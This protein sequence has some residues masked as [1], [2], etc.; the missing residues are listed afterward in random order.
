[1]Y[2]TF[3]NFRTNVAPCLSY[4]D[5]CC[6]DTKITLTQ[7]YKP[8]IPATTISDDVLKSYSKIPIIDHKYSTKKPSNGQ[9]DEYTKKQSDHHKEEHTKDSYVAHNEEDTEKTSNV[10]KVNHSKDS[11]ITNNVEVFTEK[12][13]AD[14]FIST[15][16]TI[17]PLMIIKNT[18]NV[19]FGINMEL[20]L[21]L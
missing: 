4:L 5:V 16:N 2:P 19:V 10:Y 13:I 20:V 11:Y 1:V 3:L 21:E 18:I 6:S 17:N 9:N 15:T 7:N 12:S 8:S 14:E